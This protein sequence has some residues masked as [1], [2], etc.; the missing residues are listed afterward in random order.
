MNGC[1]AGEALPSA[2]CC[3]DILRFKVDPIADT[4]CPLSPDEGCAAARE[5][6]EHYISPCGA[7]ENCICDE[8]NRLNRAVKF[9]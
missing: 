3:I 6:I 8:L 9:G 5:G 7:I 1:K 2:Y 4:A